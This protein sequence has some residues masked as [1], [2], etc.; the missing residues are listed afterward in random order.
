MSG[1]KGGNNKHKHLRCR[2]FDSHGGVTV[3]YRFYHPM[4][5]DQGFS[6]SH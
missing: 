5:H 2:S 6:R 3:Q 1:K 4:Q